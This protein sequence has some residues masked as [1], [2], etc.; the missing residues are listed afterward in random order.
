MYNADRTLMTGTLTMF[1]RGD[2]DERAGFSVSS[3]ILRILDEIKRHNAELPEDIWEPPEHIWV[4]S[5][6]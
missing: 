2:V 5:H 6:L 3:I 1:D 4:R